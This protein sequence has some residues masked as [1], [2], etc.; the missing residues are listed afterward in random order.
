MFRK[1]S[2]TVEVADF[3]LECGTRADLRI[4]VESYGDTAAPRGAILI[5][6]GYTSSH[7][8]VTPD[9]APGGAH[10]WLGALIGPNRPLDTRSFVV[11]STNVLGSCFGSSGPRDNCPRT[12]QPYGTGFF[13]VTIGDMVSAQRAALLQMGISHLRGVIGYSYGGYIAF[14]WASRFPGMVE[15]AIAIA[16]APQGRGSPAELPR[17]SAVASA[18]RDALIEWRIGNL[19]VSGFAAW[20]RERHDSE[21]RIQDELRRAATAWAD[22]FD[23]ASLFIMRRA[24]LGFSRLETPGRPRRLL[25]FEGDTLFPARGRDNLP[26]DIRCDVIGGRYGHLSPVLDPLGLAQ[27]LADSLAEISPA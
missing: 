14:E 26:P 17:L 1:T 3:G 10:G 24:A 9:G 27:P 16:S 18:G 2:G 4:A 11:I 8:A 6:H 7:R 5:A 13:P 20:L 12:G 21:L 19:S 25:L 23:A 22:E 15:G